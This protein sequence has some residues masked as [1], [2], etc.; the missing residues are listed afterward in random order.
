VKIVRAGQVVD[1]DTARR[2]AQHI[3]SDGRFR[4]SRTPRPLRGP[5]QWLGDRI[6]S[7]LDHLGNLFGSVSIWIWILLLGAVV[8][9]VVWAVSKRVARRAAAAPRGG[10][11]PSTGDDTESADAL[12]RAANAAERDGD[13]DR[14]V[15]LRFRAGLLR[16]GD[17][18]A[19]AYR[20]SV[21]TGEVRRALE[22]AR[23]DDLAG[24]F[25][26]VTYGGQAADRPAVD[27]ARR[28]WPH[29]LEETG[30]R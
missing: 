5:L 4:P 30:K 2:E 13:L 18:G 28:E 1:P 27:S 26:S 23:F 24:T 10:H 12:E 9:L 16:L 25:E 14:A 20:P 21:T 29:V 3:L 15:R 11:A 22:S 6:T 8:G 19:I 7:A 17:R